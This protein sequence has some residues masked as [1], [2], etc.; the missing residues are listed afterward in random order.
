MS[1]D[2]TPEGVAATFAGDPSHPDVWLFDR[3]S[4]AFR[5]LARR[6]PSSDDDH[7]RASRLRGPDAGTDLLA[8]RAA[9][10]RVL[11]LYLGRPPE[12]VR[13]VP[14]PGGKP[15][16]IPETADRQPL[17][18]ST[19][20]SGDL[21]CIAVSASSSVGVDIE[22][23]RDVPRALPIALR[24]FSREESNFLRSAGEERFSEEFLHLWTAKEALA[25]RHSAGLR[26]M[27]GGTDGLDVNWESAKRRLVHFEPA[28]GYLG[29]LAST[30][31]VEDVRLVT[32]AATT[33]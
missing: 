19:G 16:V 24:W 18:F 29:A 33:L 10:R 14:L 5:S 3:T 12:A 20:H 2:A 9:L 25:K 17:S 8:R 32:G 23:K 1:G 11:A 15:V 6:G 21:V 30:E 13:V 28:E 31:A 27:S 26:L 7:S 4:E 22:L